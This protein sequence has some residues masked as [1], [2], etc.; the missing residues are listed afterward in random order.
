[1]INDTGA[2]ARQRHYTSLRNTDREILR[3]TWSIGYGDPGYTTQLGTPP[4]PSTRHAATSIYKII[5]DALWLHRGACLACPWEGP[6]QRRRDAAIE[7]AHDH[8]H[9]EWRNLPILDRAPSNKGSRIWWLHVRARYPEGWFDA[10][11]PLR[12]YAVPPFD[13]HQAGAAPGG[14]F[15]LHAARPK[16]QPPGDR[17]LTLE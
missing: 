16:Q 2:I 15:L 10:G 7:D 6:D 8:T 5:T 12:L 17:Q 3:K 14:G 1:M 11:G 13:R 4:E 9:P